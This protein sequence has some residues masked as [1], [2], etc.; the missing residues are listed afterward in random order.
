M[1][2]LTA[3]I[4]ELMGAPVTFEE[5]KAK[6]GRR[7]TLRATADG[8]TAI[9]K[10]YSSERAAL[11][12]ERVGAL[13]GGPPEPRTP[14]VLLADPALRMVVLS[15]VKGP[16]LR[17]ALL[18]RDLAAC[19]RAAAAIGI[20]HRAWRGA[21][22]R[23]LG[24]HTTYRELAVLWRQCEAVPDRFGAA[25]WRAARALAD[26]WPIHGVVHRD[27]Y[28]E[29]VLVGD[30]IGLIDLDDAALGPPELDVANL[31][32]HIELLALRREMD[33]DDAMGA[34]LDGYASTGPLLDRPLLERCRKLTLLRLACIHREPALVTVAMVA[35]F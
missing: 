25:V 30:A 6:P 21:R 16:P 29:Q 4:E 22:P 8:S 18:A 23:A 19:R 33:L 27:L 12:A 2:T 14:R 9:V 11:V 10:V 17:E 32:G 15:D 3:R 26:P 24:V 7:I 1:R 34:I 13:S 35:R 28:E 20:W 31:V 5:L